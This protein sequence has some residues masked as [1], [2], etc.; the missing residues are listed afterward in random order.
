V[1]WSGDES[2][3]RRCPDDLLAVCAVV[4]VH[5]PCVQRAQRGVAQQRRRGALA[6]AGG[7]EGGKSL[8]LLFK[9]KK[10]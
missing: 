7:H 6:V 10:K 9:Q 5:A 2:S 3:T 4:A 8:S 1:K